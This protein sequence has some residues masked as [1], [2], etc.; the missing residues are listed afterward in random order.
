MQQA[1]SYRRRALQICGLILLAAGLV[2]ATGCQLIA[3]PF[4]MWG[5]EATKDVPAEYPHLHDK[6][7]CLVVWCDPDTLFEYPNVRFEV[8]EYVAYAMKAAGIKGLS[9]VS[10][11]QVT[12]L[13]A[14]EPKWEKEPP[15]R[16]GAKFHADRVLTIELTQYTMREPDNPHLYRG[17]IS[18][19]LRVYDCNS[20]DARWQWQGSTEIAYP[21]DSVGQW[22]S[23]E[24]TIRRAAMELFASEV[25]GKFYDRKIKV[26]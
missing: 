26:K 13:Q 10:N 14:R 6:E 9:F 12:D 17:H 15:G 25:A 20:P 11:R 1:P 22:G 19:N 3:A 23:D 7:V 18:A 8:S 24:R 4:L 21:P 16:L 2:A 5:P